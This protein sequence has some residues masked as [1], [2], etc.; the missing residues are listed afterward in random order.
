MTSTTYTVEDQER[1]AKATNYL[2]WQGRLILPELGQRVV[3]LG[4]GLGNFTGKLLDRELVV[5]VDI[6]PECIERLTQRYPH[7]KNLQAMVC[8][9]GSPAFADLARFRPDSC[10]CTNVLEHIEDDLRALRAMAS[11][12]EPGGVIVLYV[13]AFQGL[14][15]A[16]DWNLGHYRRYRRGSIA[17][18]GEASGLAIKKAHYVNVLGFFGWWMCSRVLRQDALTDKQ[19]GIFD[20]FAAPWLSRVEALLPPPFGQSLFVVLEKR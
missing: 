10:L 5:A 13:P 1:M 9:T 19:I 20:R 4:C 18:L 15:G 14:Y 8:D 17:R 12:L 2:A 11:I 6:N 7:A 16:V 3:E